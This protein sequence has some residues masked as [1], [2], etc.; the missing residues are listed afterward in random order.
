MIRQDESSAR[1]NGLVF[2]DNRAGGS[3][4]AHGSYGFE[5]AVSVAATLGVLLAR[6]GF[7]LRLGTAEAAPPP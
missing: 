2:L 1:A 5:R 7:S 6:R 3:G 4:Q